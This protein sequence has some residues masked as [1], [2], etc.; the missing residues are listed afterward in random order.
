MDVKDYIESGILEAYVNGLLSEEESKDVDRMADKYPQ[1]KKEI[2]AIR[3]T[4]KVYSQQA[5]GP[6]PPTLESILSSV[7]NERTESEYAYSN[8][9]KSDKPA[10]GMW[11]LAAAA[12]ALLLISVAINV[13]LLAE[14]SKLSNKITSL[15]TRQDYL[16]QQYQATLTLPSEIEDPESIISDSSHIYV[17]LSSVHDAPE[18]S[19]R[20]YWDPKSYEVYIH[21]VQLPPAPQGKQY[22]LWA[23]ING[24]SIDAGIFN[25]I[26]QIQK[27][28]KVIGPVDAFAVTLEIE[29]GSP[30]PTLDDMYVLGEVKG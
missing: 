1:I 9:N 22:Q 6:K 5:P 25:N 21:P 14:N 24:V 10:N 4:L 17:S 28:R 26:D 13:Y 3:D 8:A 18:S 11:Y 29:G 2:Q 20:V 7:S 27:L 15:T 16:A 19:A 30:I 23:I 12:L